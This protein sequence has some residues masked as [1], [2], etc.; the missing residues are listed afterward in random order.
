MDRHNTNDKDGVNLCIVDL[1]EQILREIFHHVDTVTLFVTLKKVCQKMKSHVDGYIETGRIFLMVGATESTHE[2]LYVLRRSSK[3]LTIHRK[4]FPPVTCDG[5][6]EHPGS[7]CGALCTPYQYNTKRNLNYFS[8]NNT[9]VACV[10]PTLPGNNQHVLYQYQFETDKWKI[11]YRNVSV[12]D[13]K[14][15]T[16]LSHCHCTI[17]PQAKYFSAWSTL[18]R[19]ESRDL[20]IPWKGTEVGSYEISPHLE[21]LYHKNTGNIYEAKFCENVVFIEKPKEIN[22]LCSYS[23]ICTGPKQMYYV[24]GVWKVEDVSKRMKTNRSMHVSKDNKVH[25]NR[26]LLLAELTLDKLKISWRSR[27]IENMPYRRMPF[28]FKLKN[29]LYIAGHSLFIHGFSWYEHAPCQEDHNRSL[30]DNVEHP[31]AAD[32]KCCDR[33]DLS[34]EKYYRNVHSMPYSLNTI[35]R[36][37]VAK[38][39]DESFAVISFYDISDHQEKIWTFTDDAGFKE[40]TCEECSLFKKECTDGLPQSENPRKSHYQNCSPSKRQILNIV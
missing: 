29:N 33:F 9:I 24:G 22:S 32:C 28:C 17:L 1:P 20:E 2:L 7:L 34:D 30:L 16:L 13:S 35:F 8:W 37:K 3:E 5:Y 38:N 6:S 40:H 31:D 11:I 18:T 27:Y 21:I 39:E 36:P 25:V 23:P 4:T 10:Y 14:T 15:P 12:C 26:T 19:N